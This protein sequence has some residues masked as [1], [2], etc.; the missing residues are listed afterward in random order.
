MKKVIN[1]L[2]FIIVTI[3]FIYVGSNIYKSYKP[4]YISYEYAIDTLFKFRKC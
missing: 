1:I 4:T 3:A 2:A